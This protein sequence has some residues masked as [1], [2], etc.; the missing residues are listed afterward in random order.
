VDAFGG[1]EGLIEF[2]VW[3]SK[4]GR[5]FRYE[6]KFVCSCASNLFWALSLLA[7]CD[8]MRLEVIAVISG[9]GRN[10]V[11]SLEGLVL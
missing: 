4:G 11:G 8:D 9:V 6:S 3:N 1:H 10:R 5:I 7:G 2:C